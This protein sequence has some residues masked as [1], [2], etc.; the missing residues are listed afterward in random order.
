MT[1]F[2]IYLAWDLLPI[3]SHDIGEMKWPGQFNFDF[4]TFL[5][6]SGIWLAWRH[7]FTPGGVIL[8]VIAFFG[9]MIF[10]TPYLLCA[11]VQAAGDARV[12]FLG[13]ER[14]IR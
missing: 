8:G 6:L 4:M 14:A 11:S 9:G 13:E 7:Q 12:L 3:F 10:L 1:L 2:R 5:S